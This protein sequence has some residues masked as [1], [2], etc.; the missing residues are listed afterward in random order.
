MTYL[1]TPHCSGDTI[2]F[3]ADDDVWLVAA[4]GGRAERL[5]R[6]TR[7]RLGTPPDSVG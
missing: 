5:N 7:R 2:V 3:V 1:R 6:P 4:T